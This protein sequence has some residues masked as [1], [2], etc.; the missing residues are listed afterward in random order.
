[1]KSYYIKV[2]QIRIY[3]KQFGDVA[4]TIQAGRI[5]RL[6][7]ENIS[8]HIIVRTV[9]EVLQSRSLVCITNNLKIWG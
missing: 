5:L 4:T 8:E 2:L 3:F 6:S 1:V 7:T 9:L